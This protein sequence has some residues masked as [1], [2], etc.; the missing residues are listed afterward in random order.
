MI[1]ADRLE[2]IPRSGIREIFDTAQSMGRYINLGIGEPDFR[3]P[4]FVA[5]AAIRSINSGFNK[6]TANSGLPELRYEI[7]RKLRRENGIDAD[8]ESE[9]IVTAGATQAIL[10]IMQCILNPGDEIILPTPVF[11]AYKFSAKLAGGITIEVPLDEENGYS[12]DWER[13]D[14]AVSKK[15]KALVINSPCNPTGSVLS[16]TDIRRA[17]EFADEH[18]LY[19]ISD[20]IYEKFLYD[21]AKHFS[22]GSLEE[23][24]ERIITVNGF[25]KTYAM[26]GWRL[27]YAVA[28]KDLVNAFI[29]YNMYNAVC[30]PSFAQRAA[31]TALRHSLA[32]FKPVLKEFDLRRKIVCSAFE[33]L[34]WRM[35]RPSGAFYAFPSISNYPGN[36][37]DFSMEFLRKYRVATVPGSSFGSAGERHIRICYAL[38]ERKLRRALNLLHRF[39]RENTKAQF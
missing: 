13:M 24:K 10:V 2:H 37:F 11:T 27:G 26:T 9:V 31:I 34:D 39:V 16:R 4:K 38:E 23:F 32:F 17:C 5:D 25:S 36:S 22:P 7:S 28:A 12:I 20:E 8:P 21:K 30:A 33:E 35:V 29:R 19:L 14:Q 6:Y 18:N 15:T 1:V 3:T